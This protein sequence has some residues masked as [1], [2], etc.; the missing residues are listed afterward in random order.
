MVCAR[1]VAARVAALPREGPGG[2]VHVAG[3]AGTMAALVARAVALAS[4]RPLVLV[5]ED[6][7]SARRLV[8]DLGFVWGT[9]S[10]ETAQGDVLLLTPPEASPY[11]DVN[12]DRR[13]GARCR[14]W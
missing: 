10:T 1:D 11:A 6:V 9:K 3:L 14:V 12:P 2:V 8:D 5:T 13:G 7:E 4:A